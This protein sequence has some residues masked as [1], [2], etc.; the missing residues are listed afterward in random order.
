VIDVETTSGDPERGRVMEVA[1]VQVDDGMAVAE[2]HSLVKPRCTVPPF[3]ERL[4]GIRN[5]MLHQAPLFNVVAEVLLALT[6]DRVVVAHNARFDMTALRHEFARTGLTFQRPVLCTEKLARR[7]L[8]ELP[9]HNLTSLCRHFGVAFPGAHR[10]LPD[11]MATT[12]LLQQLIA[13][14][15]PEEVERSVQFVALGEAA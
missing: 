6:R 1:V 10:A 15:G 9:H 7:L 14:Y 8:P 5:G 2:W 4:T 13:A 11:A 12:G 3:T